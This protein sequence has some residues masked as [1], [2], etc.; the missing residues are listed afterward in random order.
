M[1]LGSLSLPFHKRFL[2]ALP[3]S[4]SAAERHWFKWTYFHKRTL[5]HLQRCCQG[6]G[7]ANA[8]SRADQR[9]SAAG[10]G[11]FSCAAG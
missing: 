3:C 11:C 1:H 8:A 10:S 4:G 6:H 2:A 7:A 9:L 5:L